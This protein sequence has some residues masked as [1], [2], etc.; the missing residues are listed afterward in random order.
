[1]QILAPHL[2]SMQLYAGDYFYFTL[3]FS[4][5]FFSPYCVCISG[6]QSQVVVF[7]LACLNAKSFY[8]VLIPLK[9]VTIETRGKSQSEL[10][11]S[12]IKS[13][14]LLLTAMKN[15]PNSVLFINQGNN[16]VLHSLSYFPIKIVNGFGRIVYLPLEKLKKKSLT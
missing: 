7:F 2:I 16:L 1:M 8:V 3:S 14:A 9:F 13:S 6:I 4:K 12:C 10:A 11:S 15:N 5:H